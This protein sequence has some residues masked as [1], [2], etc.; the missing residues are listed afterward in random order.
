MSSLSRTRIDLTSASGPRR[1]ELRN[2]L[3]NVVE[4]DEVIP[5]IKWPMRMQ[6]C[7]QVG[8]NFAFTAEKPFPRGIDLLL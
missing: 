7:G 1:P 2:F 4:E 8:C 5:C 3:P 6:T